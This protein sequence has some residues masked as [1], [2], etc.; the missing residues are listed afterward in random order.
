MTLT[1][2]KTLI[3]F[4]EAACLLPS[5]RVLHSIIILFVHCQSPSPEKQLSEGRQGL[6]GSLPNLHAYHSA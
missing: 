2:V 3:H 4:T 1:K 6:P 5:Q